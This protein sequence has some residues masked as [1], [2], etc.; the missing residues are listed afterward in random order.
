MN[1]VQPPMAILFLTLLGAHTLAA[2]AAKA[3][4]LTKHQTAVLMN[5]CM[6]KRMWAD[7]KISY[8]EAAQACRDQL[9][10]HGARGASDALMA[11]DNPSK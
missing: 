10:Q 8:N 7:Q 5:D 3:L 9:K 6:K 1:R 11:S 4:P 2:D